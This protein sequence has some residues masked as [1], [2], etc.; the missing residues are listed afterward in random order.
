MPKTFARDL[1]AIKADLSQLQQVFT[2]LIIN[3]IHAMPEEGKLSIETTFDKDFVYLIVQDS[4]IGMTPETL[5]Q[6]FL[7]FFTTKDVKQGTGLGLSVV[8]GIIKAHGGDIDVKSRV[9]QGAEF[10]I[11]FPLKR[12]SSREENE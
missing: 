11:R 5:K 1:P 9:G 2:N 12:V 7:P 8:H 3:A 10:K 6:I 4:G